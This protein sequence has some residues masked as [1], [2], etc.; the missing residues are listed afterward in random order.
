MVR[1]MTALGRACWVVLVIAASFAPEG[2]AHAQTRRFA[3]DARVLTGLSVGGGDGQARLRRTPLFVE[4]G[5]HTWLEEEEQVVI[6]A[7]VRVEVED[8]ASIGAVVRAGFRAMLAP[9]ELRPSIGLVAIL[10]PF[11]L[12]G[13]DAGMVLAMHFTD[14]IAVLAHL[15]IDAY[16]YGSDLP[17]GT[18]V[19]S[20]NG[21][22]GFEVGL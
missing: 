19:T 18:V 12:F 13:V 6:G 3:V 21:G 10:A 4:A 9:I 5:M 15:V 17:T 20:F 1:A 2:K 7:A 8:R 11:T 16:L 22:L 14:R